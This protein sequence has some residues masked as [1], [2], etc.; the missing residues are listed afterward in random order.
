MVVVGFY[1]GAGRHFSVG[2][3]RESRVHPESNV[4][5]SSALS[6]FDLWNCLRSVFEYE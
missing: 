5:F 1:F 6:I 3:S 4:S 2:S